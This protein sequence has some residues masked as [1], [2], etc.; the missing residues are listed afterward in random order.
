MNGLEVQ[1]RVLVLGLRGEHQ[2][3][4]ADV[5]GA[6]ADFRRVVGAAG[7]RVP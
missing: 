3:I 6:D 2:W 7:F 4:V 5:A 1:F